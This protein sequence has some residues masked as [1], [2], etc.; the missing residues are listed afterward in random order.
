MARV[1]DS[2]KKF[3]TA[4]ILLA[5]CTSAAIFLFGQL[6]AAP[7]KLPILLA[8]SVETVIVI[9]S[10]SIIILLIHRFRYIMGKRIGLHPA[11]I[12]SFFM[13]LIA[14]IIMVFAVLDILQ[15][16][17]TTLLLGG[18]VVTIVIGLVLSTLVGTTLAGTLVLMT[19][20]FRVG[21]NVL[22]NNVPG[23]IEE[24]AAMFTRIRSDLG[25][26]I[27]IPNTALIQGSVIVTR[28]PSDDSAPQSRL[29]YSSGDR[30]YTTYL[31]E[32]G[33]VKE[34]STLHTKILLDSGKEI[35]FMN[36]SV[37]AGTV[38]I[39]KVDRPRPNSR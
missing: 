15:V 21:D 30:V 25:G 9:V 5:I 27:I 29:P 39:A 24:I 37:I 16:S 13:V 17:A 3:V 11:T 38:A 26:E 4:I 36:T 7:V 33:T 18:G 2:V 10:G 20:T 31:N 35:T 22:I 23:K 34:I 14:V 1:L 12:F 8:Q 28:I 32:E 19:N 6:I